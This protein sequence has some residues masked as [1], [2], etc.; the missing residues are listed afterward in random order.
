[1]L[2]MLP[3]LLA[4][5]LGS[6]AVDERTKRARDWLSLD[7]Y[8]VS[9]SLPSLSRTIETPINPGLQMG[10]HHAWFGRAVSG[11]TSA[12]AALF[13]FDQVFWSLSAGTGF[14]GIWRTNSGLFAG[15]GLRFD[16]ARIFTGNN[17]FVFEDGRYRQETDPG[18]SFLR[19]TLAD[20]SLGYSPSALRRL[21]L[22]PALRYAWLV[23]IPLYENDGANPWSYTLFGPSLLWMWRE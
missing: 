22:V 9:R 20:L 13:S 8:H 14:E 4:L 16:Y 23:D 5:P 11:G 12:Q 15:L 6:D 3:L 7:V 10:Y 1:M 2:T 18:R 19:I 21:G 17:N